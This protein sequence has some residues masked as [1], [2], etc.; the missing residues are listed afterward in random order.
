MD[1]FIEIGHEANPREKPT[2]NGFTHDWN[3]YVQGQDQSSIEHYVEK[4]VFHLHQ[5]FP[6]PKRGEN[7]NSLLIDWS[8]EFVYNLF[9]SFSPFFTQ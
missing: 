9:T 2:D 7:V 8:Y 4:V 5:S 3:V 1:I 6:K